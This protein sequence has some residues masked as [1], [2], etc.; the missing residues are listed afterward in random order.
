MAEE[1][2]ASLWGKFQLTEEESEDCIVPQEMLAEEHSWRPNC[3]LGC[4]LTRKGFHK[5]AFKSTMENIWKHSPLKKI[6]EVGDNLFLFQFL[7]ADDREMVLKGGPWNFDEKLVLLKALELEDKPGKGLLTKAIF[8]IRVYGLPFVAMS[9]KMGKFIGDKMG[10]FVE[11]RTDEEGM[12]IGNFLAI[13]V[14]IDVEKP[15]RRGMKIGTGGGEKLVVEFKYERLSTFCY[16]CGILG[17]TD[18][19]CSVA[20]KWKKDFPGRPFQYCKRL[21]VQPKQW[22]PRSKGTEFEGG[23]SNR[24]FDGGLGARMPDL[25]TEFHNRGKKAVEEDK[26]KEV[27]SERDG[28]ED[29]FFGAGDI[30]PHKGFSNSNI[31]QNLEE[32]GQLKG[33]VRGEGEPMG[34][35]EPISETGPVAVMSKAQHDLLFGDMT[36]LAGPLQIND[37]DKEEGLA[38]NVRIQME[39]EPEAAT[40][41]IAWKRIKNCPIKGKENREGEIAAEEQGKR[42]REVIEGTGKQ[43]VEA[44]G[45]KALKVLLEN[46]SAGAVAQL[47]REP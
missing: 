42:K 15:L 8:G 12:G 10:R 34:G 7:S 33:N 43:D 23:N 22:F 28:R 41:K 25:P 18:K 17:H 14:E 6:Y 2:L 26:G 37:S 47:R 36:I 40:R 4:L 1:E 3:L 31:G 5:E 20:I 24:G 30:P 39:I 16:G 13:R 35:K 29:L 45:R 38:Q 46:Q 9:E 44:R 21:R 27:F 11:M 19:E 32:I